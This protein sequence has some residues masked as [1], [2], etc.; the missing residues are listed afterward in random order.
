VANDIDAVKADGG[1]KKMKT[2]GRNMPY[3]SEV[4]HIDLQPNSLVDHMVLR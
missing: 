1:M 3:G 2:D 4:S